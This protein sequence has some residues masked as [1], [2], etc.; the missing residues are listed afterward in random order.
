LAETQKLK[1]QATPLNTVASGVTVFN[2]AFEIF[3]WHLGVPLPPPVQ[4]PSLWLAARGSE[5]KRS[6]GNKLTMSPNIKLKG[7]S[8]TDCG[9]L[10][11]G[12]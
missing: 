7:A 9:T 12:W 3:L 1:P 8:I 6:G 4:L 10:V 5:H 2:T 11:E